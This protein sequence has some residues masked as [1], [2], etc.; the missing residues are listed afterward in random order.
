ML[1]DHFR[2]VA[3]HYLPNQTPP[4]YTIGHKTD[5]MSKLY[6]LGRHARVEATS[7]LLTQAMPSTLVVN[8]NP[9]ADEAATMVVTQACGSRSPPQ[10]ALF[11]VPLLVEKSP[12]PPC[13]PPLL[14]QPP[15]QS[16]AAGT[17][18]E[19]T[20]AEVGRKGPPKLMGNLSPNQSARLVVQ[21]LI[22]YNHKLSPVL[23]PAPTAGASPLERR[24]R[25][26]KE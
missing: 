24:H 10:N 2:T 3:T 14:T 9:P 17:Q 20:F 8:D 16:D 11:Y 21:S 5:S 6:C 22:G 25:L 19:N 15:P 12:K 1:L 7:P 18:L 4:K 23:Q 26:A 13:V